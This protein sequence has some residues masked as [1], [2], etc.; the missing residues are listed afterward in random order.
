MQ[1]KRRSIERIRRDSRKHPRISVYLTLEGTRMTKLKGHQLSS[2]NLSQGG[3]MIIISPPMPKDNPL[4]IGEKLTVSF[5]IDTREGSVD[6]PG[7]IVW[8]KELVLTPDNE[9]AS[10]A[11][12]RFTEIQPKV[13]EMIKNFLSGKT[14]DDARKRAKKTC[15]DCIHFKENARSKYA[16]CKLHRITVLN[17]D[18]DLTLSFN[19]IFTNPCKDLKEEDG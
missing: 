7:Q 18:Q 1:D 16:F 8:I 19:Q 12:V 10:C 2:H 9:Q 15:R 14:L 4:L 6:I 5:A 11:G 17:S 13:A 3:M